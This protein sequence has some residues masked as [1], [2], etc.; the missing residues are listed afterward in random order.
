MDFSCTDCNIVDMESI[1]FTNCV[2]FYG[3]KVTFIVVINVAFV[4]QYRFIWI[5]ESASHAGVYTRGAGILSSNGCT[6]DAINNIIVSGEAIL[7]A[8]NSGKPLGGPDSAPR[9]SSLWGGSC[10]PIPKNSTGAFRFWPSEKSWTRPCSRTKYYVIGLRGDTVFLRVMLV[11][12]RTLD[13]DLLPC[14]GVDSGRAPRRMAE[15]QRLMP[16][17]WRA[18]YLTKW[19]PTATDMQRL[20]LSPAVDV[21]PY[22]MCVSSYAVGDFTMRMFLHCGENK[23]KSYDVGR[24]ACWH[25]STFTSPSCKQQNLFWVAIYVSVIY[26]PSTYLGEDLELLADLPSLIDNL[27]YHFLLSYSY[28]FIS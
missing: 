18:R 3:I 28:A 27:T 21:G 7:S 26:S 11:V 20:P 1:V 6:I 8:E 4:Q 16:T 15:G 14:G 22:S 5:G 10:C 17:I 13:A 12:S 24:A 25:F 9:T 2:T 23:Q 19:R